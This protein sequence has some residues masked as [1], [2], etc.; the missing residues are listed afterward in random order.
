M[1]LIAEL[2]P[3]AHF[4]YLIRDVALLGSLG[5]VWA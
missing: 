5:L 2:L 1:P 4:V 3:E